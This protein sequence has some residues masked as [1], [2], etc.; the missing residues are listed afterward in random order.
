MK[1]TTHAKADDRHE[2]SEPAKYK[3]RLYISG[4]TPS[5]TRALANIKAIAEK[6]L[7]GQYNL[8]VIDAYQQAELVRDQ[9]IVVLP[10]LVKDL[11]APIRRVIGDLSNE[12]RVVLGL[13]LQPEGPAG[14]TR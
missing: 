4:A 10:T 8:E 6:H 7:H 3:L 9:Q 13:G 5:S 12:D 2:V 1:T 14:P 11:P